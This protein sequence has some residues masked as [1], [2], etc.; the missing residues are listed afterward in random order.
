MGRFVAGRK[1]FDGIGDAVDSL[2][3]SDAE[4]MTERAIDEARMTAAALSRLVEVLHTR[5]IVTTDDAS[6]IAR[7]WGGAIEEAVDSPLPT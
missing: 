6:F 2:L 5:G 4:G 3:D 7:G 1:S